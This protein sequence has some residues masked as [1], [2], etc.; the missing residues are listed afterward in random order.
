M[1]HF[2]LIRYELN[3]DWLRKIFGNILY[4]F[5]I[6]FPSDFVAN[7]SHQNNIDAMFIVLHLD[8]LPI[9]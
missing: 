1:F 5:Y 9:L 7:K 2:K 4:K 8:A 6:R 3:Q